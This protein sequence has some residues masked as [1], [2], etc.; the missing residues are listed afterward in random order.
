MGVI[1]VQDGIIKGDVVQGVGPFLHVGGVF[2]VFSSERTL[3]RCSASESISSQASL[4][5]FFWIITN[6]LESGIST[7]STV[8]SSISLSLAVISSG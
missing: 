5:G 2:V 1:G 4:M 7:K 8:F 6:I 3:K